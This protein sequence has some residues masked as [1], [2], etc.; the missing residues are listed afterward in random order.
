M[1]ANLAAITHLL[2]RRSGAR[3][4]VARTAPGLFAGP[5]VLYGA[6]AAMVCLVFV[7][8]FIPA[9]M[10][11]VPSGIR[12]A[13]G[14]VTQA[15][16]S[17]WIIGTSLG[18][19]ALLLVLPP[20]AGSFHLRRICARVWMF[21]AFVGASSV[22]SGLVT[23]A[24]KILFGRARPELFESYG[25]TGFVPFSL[26]AQFWSFPSGHATT[27]VALA[28]AL[29]I[30]WPRGRWLLALLAAI[31]ALSRVVIGAHFLSDI[32]IGACVGYAT[33]QLIALWMARRRLGLALHCTGSARRCRLVRHARGC[34]ARRDVR[35]LAR[36]IVP[37]FLR[38]QGSRTS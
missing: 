11:L 26:A 22:L 10:Q 19:C 20:R 17:G 38:V 12:A 4:Q 21:C 28:T 14:I 7:D 16:K 15:G 1:R 8:P 13:A 37:R 18:I 3:A 6:L 30:I 25:A 31:V 9:A 24:G 27:I 34:G 36:M 23:L 33:S 2:R 35:C 29:G 5:A 32:I